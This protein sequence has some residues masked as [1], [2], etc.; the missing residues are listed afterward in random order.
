ML[1]VEVDPGGLTPGG[2]L[3]RVELGHR[4]VLVALALDQQ[5]RAADVR[6]FVGDVPLGEARVKPHVVPA[7]ERGIGVAVVTGHL[8]S[9]VSVLYA[10]LA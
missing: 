8:R 5:Q 7:V 9:E 6:D 2:S 10:R 3:D 4:P 1:A